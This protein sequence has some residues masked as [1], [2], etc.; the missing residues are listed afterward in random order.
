MNLT[1]EKQTKI[2]F[3]T[4]YFITIGDFYTSKTMC[5]NLI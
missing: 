2:D 3:F 5:D 4:I 1:R